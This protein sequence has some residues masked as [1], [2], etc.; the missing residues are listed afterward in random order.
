MKMIKTILPENVLEVRNLRNR[1]SPKALARKKNLAK[2]K[3]DQ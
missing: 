1:L 3:I 2:V